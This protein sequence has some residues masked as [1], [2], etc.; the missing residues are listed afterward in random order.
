M[1]KVHLSVHLNVEMMF[2]TM[3]SLCICFQAFAF[4]AKQSSSSPAS[5]IVSLFR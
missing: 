1:D 4:H 2:C 3:C 5:M